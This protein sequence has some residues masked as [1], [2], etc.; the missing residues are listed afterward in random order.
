MVSTKKI[1]SITTET[2]VTWKGWCNQHLLDLQVWF[3]LCFVLFWGFIYWEREKEHKQGE[4]GRGERKSEK[5]TLHWSGSPVWDSIPGLQDHNLR[6]RQKPPRRPLR[7]VCGKR[8]WSLKAKVQGKLNSL[9]LS[10]RESRRWYH[11]LSCVSSPWFLSEYAV[12]C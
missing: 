6:W 12:L 9:S 5:Q 1:V 10:V 4:R 8:T 3:L 7:S 2:G 11:L